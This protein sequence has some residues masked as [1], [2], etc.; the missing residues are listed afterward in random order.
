MIV[1]FKLSLSLS[2]SLSLSLSLLSLCQEP[3][4]SPAR[5]DPQWSVDDV[6][7]WLKTIGLPHLAPVFRS[8]RVDGK[9]LL[10]FTGADAAKMG[11]NVSTAAG[12]KYLLLFFRNLSEL[13]SHYRWAMSKS[14]REGQ[15]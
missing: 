15:S 14:H 12:Y 6:S 9:A 2:I 3:S 5:E 10:A 1:S 8:H 7:E 11:I 13:I 4:P